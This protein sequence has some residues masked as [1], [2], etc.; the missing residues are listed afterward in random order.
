MPRSGGAFLC[1]SQI[2]RSRAGN[3]HAISSRKNLRE[4]A[5]GRAEIAGVDAV[6]QNLGVT[7]IGRLLPQKGVVTDPNP[8]LR[9]AALALAIA[10]LPS[11]CAQNQEAATLLQ[12]WDADH[13]GTLNLDEVR[14]AALA[15]FDKLDV[16]HEGTL[17]PQELGGRLPRRAFDD[18]DMDNDS[19][20]SKKEYL[21][22][23]TRRFEATDSDHDGS[24]TVQ[25]LDSPAG[26]RL[27]KLLH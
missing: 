22:L 9:A 19:T 14:R 7:S 13:E 12:T 2:D 8:A 4:G 23:V 5:S 26:H 25:E 10:L 17:S 24:L 16:D 1:T 20:L 3:W 6:D 15:E 11:A 18:A 21:A 27:M